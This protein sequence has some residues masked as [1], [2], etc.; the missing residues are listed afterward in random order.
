MTS[1]SYPD[2]KVTTPSKGDYLQVDKNW[3]KEFHKEA[4]YKI[5]YQHSIRAASILLETERSKKKPPDKNSKFLKRSE[6]QDTDTDTVKVVLDTKEL[7]WSNRLRG[8]ALTRGIENYV[9]KV[10]YLLRPE[11]AYNACLHFLARELG[12]ADTYL[13]Q[14]QFL[15]NNSGINT[16]L[17]EF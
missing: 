15:F 6:Q 13:D 1:L 7:V 11:T 2:S 12:G 4:E 5:E 3:I 14:R 17:K 8:E 10:L 9:P 16:C